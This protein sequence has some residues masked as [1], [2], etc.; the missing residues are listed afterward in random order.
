M[1]KY[2]TLFVLGALN[3]LHASVHVIQM[4]QSVFLIS[5]A[6]NKEENWLH[7][8]MENPLISILWAAL[9]LLTMYLGY[10]DYKIHKKEI[11]SH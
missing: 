1:K 7:N 8:L 5:Y 11:H 10:R 6:T 4:L 2:K 9:G 3:I